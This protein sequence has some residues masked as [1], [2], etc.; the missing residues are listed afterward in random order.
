MYEWVPSLGF[1]FL[2]FSLRAMVWTLT[3]IDP[4]VLV[5]LFSSCLVWIVHLTVSCRAVSY[6]PLFFLRLFS[7]VSNLLDVVARDVQRCSLEGNGRAHDV[8]RCPFGGKL[9]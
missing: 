8:K 6:S 7:I 9:E 2:V 1:V 4:Q 5:G 3:L